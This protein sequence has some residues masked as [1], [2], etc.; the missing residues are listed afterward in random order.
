MLQLLYSSVDI[1]VLAL[2]FNFHLASYGWYPFIGPVTSSTVSLSRTTT[3]TTSST[4]RTSA[5][6]TAS[7]KATP[8][9]SKEAT[10]TKGVTEESEE[11]DDDSQMMLIFYFFTV[12]LTICIV[13]MIVVIAVCVGLVCHYKGMAY[14]TVLS[15]ATILESALKEK[16]YRTNNSISPI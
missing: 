6:R 10:P 1:N 4:S 2:C 16:N 3:T 11:G 13:I 9:S 14:N 5:V 15:S 8:T 12:L 7:A